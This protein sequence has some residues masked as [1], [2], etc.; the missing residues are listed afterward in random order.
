M[1]PKI[2]T[3]ACSINV[4]YFPNDRQECSLTIGS[5]Y[6][7]AE[8]IQIA[9]SN[10][11]AGEIQSS[12]LSLTKVH[13]E[14]EIVSLVGQMITADYAQWG[15]YSELSYKLKLSRK[16][17]FYHINFIL[18]TIVIGLLGTCM[19]FIP[20]TS[21]EKVSFGITLLLALTVNQLIVSEKLP[22]TSEN[23][24]FLCIYFLVT[25]ILN[26]FAICACLVV[27]NIHTHASPYPVPYTLKFFCFKML[28][29]VFSFQ[30]SAFCNTVSIWC[31]TKRRNFKKRQTFCGVRF[32]ASFD[33]C[34]NVSVI[35][36][37]S[38]ANGVLC[39][40][41]VTI[42]PQLRPN[43][44]WKI[45]QR[46]MRQGKLKRELWNDAGFMGSHFTNGIAGG[47]GSSRFDAEKMFKSLHDVV[48]QM[49][50]NKEDWMRVATIIDKAIGVVYLVVMVTADLILLHTLSRG[51][52]TADLDMSSEGGH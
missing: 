14:W 23:L 31:K 9:F 43:S 13:D 39:S 2:L 24:P 19:F 35:H 7:T 26:S 18:P 6:Y 12:D 33:E 5:W 8:Y 40:E 30:F 29:P 3:A 47:K 25:I 20:I 4:L 28:G 27:Y 17:L 10:P 50:K 1:R 46:A 36:S 22:V 49:S 37:N 52:S 41:K 21:G 11:A 51:A 34:H 15:N 45:V 38:N 42:L 44:K 48:D 16:P 32:K